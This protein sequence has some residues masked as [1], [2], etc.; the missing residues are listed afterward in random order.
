MKYLNS[1]YASGFAAAHDINYVPVVN[2]ARVLEEGHVI[3]EA[4]A[5]H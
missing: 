3:D 4:S 1:K 2:G 5:V